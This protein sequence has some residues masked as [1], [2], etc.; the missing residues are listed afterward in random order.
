MILATSAQREEYARDFLT[1]LA[2]PDGHRVS[3]SYQKSWFAND[4]LGTRLIGRTAVI[5]FCEARAPRSEFDFLAVRHAC[6]DELVPS[7]LDGLRAASAITVVFRLGSLIAVTDAEMVALQVA[8]KASLA[9]VEHRP[10]PA[11]HADQD[12]ALFV[13]EHPKLAEAAGQPDQA[14]S[15]R[16]LSEELGK[17]ATLEKAFFFR[18]GALRDA[19]A[20]APHGSLQTEERGTLRHVYPLQPSSEYELPMDAYSKSGKTPYSD[21]IAVASSSEQLTVQAITQSSAGR[22][23]QAVLV[24]RA[25]EVKR[26]QVATLIIQGADGFE[27]LVPRVELATRIKPN[28][29]LAV[30]LSVVIA[31]GV[32]LGGL[33]KD[34]LGLQD[35]VLYPLKAVGGLIVGGATLLALGRVPGVGK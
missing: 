27:H 9:S 13:F 35:S 33:P 17:T 7:S 21:A 22:A 32:V 16:V 6:I 34:A 24:L 2:S 19:S 4:L 8:W 14:R 12:K 28:L 25:G 23:S 18:V 20:A 26:A 10:R 29:G 30:L 5:V 1:C 3:F 31:F 15:W 11:D